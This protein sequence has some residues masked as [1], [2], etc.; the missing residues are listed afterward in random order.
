MRTEEIRE[1]TEI[2]REITIIG[3]DLTPQQMNLKLMLYVKWSISIGLLRRG[4]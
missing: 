4:I 3:N 1:E 2:G